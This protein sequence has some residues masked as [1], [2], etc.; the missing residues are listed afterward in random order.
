MPGSLPLR[1]ETLAGTCT[2]QRSKSVSNIR[3]SPQQG[4]WERE[5]ANGA[6]WCG[7]H[8]GIE[9]PRGECG[10]GSA[11]QVVLLSPQPCTTTAQTHAHPH[12]VCK[13][14]AQW[15]RHQKNQCHPTPPTPTAHGH[16][17]PAKQ[18]HHLQSDA[19][20]KRPEPTT[21]GEDVGQGRAENLTRITQP[22]TVQM[23]KTTQRPETKKTHL[24]VAP[25]AT[26]SC[27]Q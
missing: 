7:R 20:S 18:G 6:G 10:M 17:P 4:G 22:G 26:S 21:D 16:N 2:Q 1:R 8:V 5:A 12:T 25:T 9:E 3:G 14:Q 15:K 19:N 13:H 23:L 11:A 24:N 27:R